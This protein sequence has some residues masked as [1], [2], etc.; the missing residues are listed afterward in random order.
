MNFLQNNWEKGIQDDIIFQHTLDF[1]EC[2]VITNAKNAFWAK[3]AP[4]DNCP[5]RIAAKASTNNVKDILDL[6]KKLAS[7]EV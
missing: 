6:I 1:F 5:R 2:G 3:V 7:E 4:N